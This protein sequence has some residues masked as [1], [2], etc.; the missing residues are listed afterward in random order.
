MVALASKLCVASSATT[1]ADG[2]TSVYRTRI[3][4]DFFLENMDWSLIFSKKYNLV[5]LEVDAPSPQLGIAASAF[6]HA[7]R[8]VA[9][10][11]R[12]FERSDSLED[13][14]L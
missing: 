3:M 10:I 14:S 4:A 7:L 13:L 12:N 9:I 6:G 2:D 5:L 8:Y 11:N 1:G